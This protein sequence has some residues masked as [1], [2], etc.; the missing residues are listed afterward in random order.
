MSFLTV[1]N[2]IFAG[3]IMA[4]GKMT[5]MHMWPKDLKLIAYLILTM[6]AAQ[7]ARRVMLVHRLSRNHA[8]SSLRGSLHEIVEAGQVEAIKVKTNEIIWIVIAHGMLVVSV[9]MELAG[10]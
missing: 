1:T 8:P 9:L 7:L 6:I 10:I 3:A 2:E 4:V 5:T